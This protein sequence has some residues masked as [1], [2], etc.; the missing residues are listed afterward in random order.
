[1]VSKTSSIL[2]N[3]ISAMSSI[4]IALLILFYCSLIFISRSFLGVVPTTVLIGLGVIALFLWIKGVIH[5]SK[6][7]EGKASATNHL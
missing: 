7:E 2:M 1:M 6:P 4:V 5:T 3:V